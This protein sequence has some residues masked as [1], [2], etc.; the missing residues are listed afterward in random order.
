MV[1]IFEIQ[2]TSL[3]LFYTFLIWCGIAFVIATWK[4]LIDEDT[5]KE[6]DN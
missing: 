1:N 6:L 2:I 5:T 3:S 4:Y